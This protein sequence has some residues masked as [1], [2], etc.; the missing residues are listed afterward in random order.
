MT[1]GTRGRT[2][3]EALDALGA[4]LD[5]DNV[6]DADLTIHLR[7]DNTIDPDEWPWRAEAEAP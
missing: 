3:R 5:A 4:Q 2:R 6:L 7:Q 1:Y